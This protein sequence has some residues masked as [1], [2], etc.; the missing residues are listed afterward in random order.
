MTARFPSMIATMRNSIKT[1]MHSCSVP[2]NSL[3]IRVLELLR[4]HGFIQGYSY[5]YTRRQL[6]QGFNHGYPRVTI[7]FKYTDHNSPV[8]KD[9]QSFKNT[10]SNYYYLNPKHRNKFVMSDHSIYILSNPQGLKLT[11]S[12]TLQESQGNSS[13][14]DLTGKIIAQLTI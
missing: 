2:V 8:L 7:V 3:C 5:L 6:R 10:R 11:F 1:G 9:I 14:K 13:S 4:N 12:S